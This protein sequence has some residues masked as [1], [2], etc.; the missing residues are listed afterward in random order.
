MTI[1]SVGHGSP[2]G[3]R[4]KTVAVFGFLINLNWTCMTT[5]LIKAVWVQGAFRW[6]GTR[7]R[8]GL[9]CTVALVVRLLGRQWHRPPGLAP[10][11]RH[12]VERGLQR[13]FPR[14]K[15]S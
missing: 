10:F 12:P 11:L 1:R 5:G 15:Y 14:S 9:V 8:F 3:G 6:N 4:N 7:Q 13:R 2:N